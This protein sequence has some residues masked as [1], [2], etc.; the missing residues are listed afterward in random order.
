MITKY[1]KKQPNY[2]NS[3]ILYFVWGGRQLY[4]IFALLVFPRITF[5]EWASDISSSALR[6]KG[7]VL[8]V[9]LKF[10]LEKRGR[11]LRRDGK[12]TTDTGFVLPDES[13]TRA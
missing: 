1:I 10:L 9:M 4:L 11:L 8:L 13:S 7:V 3:H 5:A 2:T 6:K 12:R